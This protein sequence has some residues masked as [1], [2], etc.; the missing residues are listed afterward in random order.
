[1]LQMSWNSHTGSQQAH[2][3]G[4]SAPLYDLHQDRCLKA[5]RDSLNMTDPKAGCLFTAICTYQLCTLTS[6]D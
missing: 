5:G 2:S 4:S 3:E 6:S 1:M